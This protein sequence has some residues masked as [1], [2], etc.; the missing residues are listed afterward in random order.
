[1][2]LVLNSLAGDA[3]I[4]SWE[5]IAPY[6]RFIEIG[7]KDI[8]SHNKLPMFQFARN[9]TFSAVDLASLM[10]DRPDDVQE[11]LVRLVDLFNRKIL[12]VPSPLKVFPVTD[13]EAAFRYLQSGNNPGKVVVEVDS[14]HIVPVNAA[15]Y[16]ALLDL[17][18]HIKARVKPTSDWTFGND[19]TILI[20]GGLGAQGRSIAKWMVSKGARHLVLL[21]R[22]GE[23]NATSTV[24]AF[25]ADMRNQGV[26]LYCPACDVAN[27]SSLATVLGHCAIHMPPI[28]GCVQAAMNLRV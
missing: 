13:F 16:P 8:Y 10:I 5:C 18:E 19:D 6:G 12:H 28:R 9:V 4:A 11:I 1:M 23:D 17:A 7:K 14:E 26:D 2:D 15:R 21:S 27:P 24:K 3:L 25:A 22:T 20:S